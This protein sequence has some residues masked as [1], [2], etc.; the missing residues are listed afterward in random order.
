[1]MKSGVFGLIVAS[2][3]LFQLGLAQDTTDVSA[4]LAQLTKELPSCAV[5]IYQP[6]AE[7]SKPQIL[8]LF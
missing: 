7:N 1:M 3:S 8:T 4:I 5:S 6:G 2:A